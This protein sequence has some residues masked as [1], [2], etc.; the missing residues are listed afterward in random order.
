MTLEL[1][2]QPFFASGHYAQF[3]E[4]RAPR[5]GQFN[6]YG[7]DIGT[8]ATVLD[9]LG[10]I[11]KYTIDPDGSGPSSAF[12]FQNPDYTQRSLR[13]NAVFRWEYR[14]GSV[15]YLAW[16]HSRFDSD[17]EGTLDL[18]RERTALLA[19]HP[20]NIFLVKASWWIPR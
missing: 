7:T 6:V 18:S 19:S 11:A 3:K 9:S 13:G 5:Q 4:F 17:H 1:Y 14:P 12:T 16:T 8:V 2:A 20:N 15:L 10:A